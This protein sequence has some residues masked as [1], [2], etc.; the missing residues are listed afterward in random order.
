VSIPYEI[1]GTRWSGRCAGGWGVGEDQKEAVGLPRL[2]GIV[3][4]DCRYPQLRRGIAWRLVDFLGEKKR[5]SGEERPS[6]L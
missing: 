2:A 3:F 5:G 1:D 4:E 6:Y